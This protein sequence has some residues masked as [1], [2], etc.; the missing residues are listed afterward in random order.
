MIDF[1]T[2]VK[3]LLDAPR[4]KE[5]ELLLGVVQAK[6]MP[7]CSSRHGIVSLQEG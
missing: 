6:S 5:V 7:T 2:G 4:P 3:I 1:D